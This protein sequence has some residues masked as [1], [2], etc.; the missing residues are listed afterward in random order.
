MFQV[1]VHCDDD[2]G[3][4]G[5]YSQVVTLYSSITLGLL[6]NISYMQIKAT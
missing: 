6:V 4:G 5:G 2:G 3:G 1:E